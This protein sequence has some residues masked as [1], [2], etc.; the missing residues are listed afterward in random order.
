MPDQASLFYPARCL[1][2]CLGSAPTMDQDQPPIGW[3]SEA[4]RLSEACGCQVKGDPLQCS[5]MERGRQGFQI[6]LH[7]YTCG[8]RRWKVSLPRQRVGTGWS[9]GSLQAKPFHDSTILYPPSW[10]KDVLP[11]FLLF[12]ELSKEF[13]SQLEIKCPQVFCWEREEGKG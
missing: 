1:Y 9:H 11:C 10:E 6:K 7:M 12:K 13:S 2:S 5:E 8:K 4:K 3:K